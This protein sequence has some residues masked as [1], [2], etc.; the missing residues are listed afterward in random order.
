LFI[1]VELAEDARL[2]CEK[3]KEIVMERNAKY[4]DSI[5]TATCD[6]AEGT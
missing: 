5:C 3:L 2:F 1:G 6:F 4:G